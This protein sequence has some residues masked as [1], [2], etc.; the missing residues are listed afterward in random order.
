MSTAR[1]KTGPAAAGGGVTREP[2]KLSEN[3]AP[4]SIAPV[5]SLPDRWLHISAFGRRASTKRLRSILLKVADWPAAREKSQ[6]TAEKN[7]ALVSVAPT[8]LHRSKAIC[9]SCHNRIDP[10]GFA[11]E[12]YDVLGRW[13]T[14]DSGKPIDNRGQLPDGTKI[15]GPDQLKKVLLARK[16]VFLR[17]LTSKMLGYALG[18]GLTP[19]DSC[20]VD[21]ILDQLEKEQF[22]AQALIR[23]IVLSVPFRYQAGTIA[24]KTK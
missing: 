19:S 7:L 13:R 9:A 1:A 16:Q 10:L 22:K 12:N 11:L 17:H 4:S 24:S 20:T 6:S 15:D 3:V 2:Q 21:Q 23:G 8:K 14:E 18:R 5:K